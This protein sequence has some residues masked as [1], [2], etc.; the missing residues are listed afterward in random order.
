MKADL[1]ALIRTDAGV[2]AAAGA[3]IWW[4]ERPQGS[5]LPAAVLHVIGGGDDYHLR[6]RLTL[7]ETR[8]QADCWA[9]RYAEADALAAALRAR[10]SGYLGTVGSTQFR[11]IFL[12]AIRDLPD[13]G[14]VAAGGGLATPRLF[15]VSL[16]FI[17]HHHSTGA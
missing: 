7:T 1:L 17:V 2:A 6:G 12:D 5:A 3:R 13:W 11:G 15:R 8:V 4:A 9:E 10:L 16:D 14:G